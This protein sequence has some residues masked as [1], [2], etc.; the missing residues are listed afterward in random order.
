M[1]WGIGGLGVESVGVSVVLKHDLA[2]GK[3]S[4]GRGSF[5]TGC[6]KRGHCDGFMT[7]SYQED[8]SVCWTDAS[9][10]SQFE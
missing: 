1:V 4:C 5:S 8:V 6:R 3:K 9:L 2:T 10:A 7:R